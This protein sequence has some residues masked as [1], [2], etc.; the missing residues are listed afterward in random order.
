ME[1][2]LTCYVVNFFCSDDK[3]LN[4]YSNGILTDDY[5]AALSLQRFVS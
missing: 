2:S 5:N 3:R 4:P 1:Y